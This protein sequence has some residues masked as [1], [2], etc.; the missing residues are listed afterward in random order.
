MLIPYIYNIEQRNNNFLN[1]IQDNNYLLKQPYYVI[2]ILSTY[3]IFIDIVFPEP[4][5][6]NEIEGYMLTFNKNKKLWYDICDNFNNIKGKKRT[7][8][9]NTHNCSL[10]IEDGKVNHIFKTFLGK[11]ISEQEILNTLKFEFP[12]IIRNNDYEELIMIGNKDEIRNYFLHKEILFKISNFNL[13]YGITFNII[14]YTYETFQ[15]YMNLHNL[16][17]ITLKDIS[18]Q[19]NKEQILQ[20]KTKTKFRFNKKIHDLNVCLLEFLKES[21]TK[22]FIKTNIKENKYYLFLKVN[23]K[24]LIYILKQNALLNRRNIQYMKNSFSRGNETLMLFD[25]GNNKHILKLSKSTISLNPKELEE[26]DLKKIIIQ[27]SENFNKILYNVS[28]YKIIQEQF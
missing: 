6:L 13:P 27:N 11:N 3:E 2:D 14:K 1:L 25:D 23:N 16:N 24:N 9:I 10:I 8:L 15:T 4:I 7:D 17:K 5:D 12:I 21:E 20:Y 18:L 26:V 19:E 28:D 22:C